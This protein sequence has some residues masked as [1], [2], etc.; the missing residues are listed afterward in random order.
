MKQHEIILNGPAASGAEFDVTMMGALL[1][2]VDEA[3]QGS[4]RLII[5]GRS[6]TSGPAPK[7][8]RDASNMNASVSGSCT[9]LAVRSKPLHEVDPH[10]FGQV[11]LFEESFDPTM[12]AYDVF[13]AALNSTV[14]NGRNV[15][16]ATGYDDALL[17]T[18]GKFGQVFDRG[19]D[20]ITF[21]MSNGS[22]TGAASKMLQMNR[23]HTNSFDE[24]RKE[25]PPP[26]RAMVAGM[27]NEIR[28]DNLTFRIV[29]N[30]SAMKGSAR[31]SFRSTLQD[32]WGKSVLAEGL[33]T[34]GKN[35]TPQHL[36]AN[37]IQLATEVDLE[38]F[39]RMPSSG[40][41]SPFVVTL[42]RTEQT[43]G[44]APALYGS[45]P[46]DETDD[47]FDA[48]LDDLQAMR[49]ENRWRDQRD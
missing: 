39:G 41:D 29:M 15:T 10:M 8:L 2:T 22:T 27:L 14:T 49:E 7:W 18:F 6:R 9:L 26:R 5:E 47:E 35:G 46:G 24:L 38:M 36:A 32:L 25:I 19:I 23:G 21:G 42:A 44:R 37:H 12:S 30:G 16:K 3:V 48:M 34:F 43:T 4:L 40:V 33:I 45:W 31:K 13:E 28:S 20:C 17:R 1:N 11:N